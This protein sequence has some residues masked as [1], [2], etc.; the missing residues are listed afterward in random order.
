MPSLP[1][2]F[3]FFPKQKLGIQTLDE[4]PN[5]KEKGQMTPASQN[6]DAPDIQGTR[7]LVKSALDKRRIIIASQHELEKSWRTASTPAKALNRPHPG[8]GL[9]ENR[10]KKILIAAVT[11]KRKIEALQQKTFLLFQNITEEKH[12]GQIQA[13]TTI[14]DLLAQPDPSQQDISDKI[15]SFFQ[16]E[17]EINKSFLRNVKDCYRN[18]KPLLEEAAQLKTEDCGDQKIDK[19]LNLEITLLQRFLQSAKDL[20]HY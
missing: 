4:R 2:G 10:Q 18:T 16:T 3:F 19:I 9:P 15:A 7:R 11:K 8:E 13:G 5:K 20:L 17:N 12:E 1:A 6:K 14:L